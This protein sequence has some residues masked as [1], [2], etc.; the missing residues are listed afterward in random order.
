MCLSTCPQPPLLRRARPRVPSVPLPPR[1][2]FTVLL[3]NLAAFRLQISW[4]SVSSSAPDAL[5][6]EFLPQRPYVLRCNQGVF[7]CSRALQGLT[8]LMEKRFRMSRTATSDGGGA[9]TGIADGD[10]ARVRPHQLIPR[11][12]RTLRQE[13]LVVSRSHFQTLHTA[14]RKEA[15]LVEDVH[16]VAVALHAHEDALQPSFLQR[17]QGALLSLALVR[18]P[19][20]RMEGGHDVQLDLCVSRQRLV[21]QDRTQSATASIR[22]LARGG[23][24]RHGSR[25]A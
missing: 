20:R 17:G 13:V 18:A 2:R 15:T 14:N 9:F 8:F 5:Q 11:P 1:E 21:H 25:R 6:C 16:L 23:A 3:P 4:W 10:G 12:C 24:S 22:S 19:P 7:W